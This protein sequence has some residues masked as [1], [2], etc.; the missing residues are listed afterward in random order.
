MKFLIMMV[1]F[2]GFVIAEEQQQTKVGSAVE[3]SYFDPT[4]EE[5]QM[6][7]TNEPIEK[8]NTSPNPV[9]D[10]DEYKFNEALI[11][12]KY[13]EDQNPYEEKKKVKQSQED[14]SEE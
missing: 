14:N 4:V 1:L 5:A 3:E 7:G 12:G 6:P 2:S 8:V 13:I 9:P 10:T 11:D